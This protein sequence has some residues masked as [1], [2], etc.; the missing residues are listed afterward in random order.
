MMDSEGQLNTTQAAMTSE[1][2]PHKIDLIAAI[3]ASK[4]AV[5][6]FTHLPVDAVS[7]CTKR[8]GT[9]LAHVD[10]IESPARLGDN[11]LL[12]TYQVTLDRTG[13][14]VGFERIARYHRT[15][16]VGSQ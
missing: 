9:W 3:R 7:A 10:V 11:D 14:I 15:D 1:A 4:Q 5:A 2:D 13:A 8:E 12:S 6:E 16:A